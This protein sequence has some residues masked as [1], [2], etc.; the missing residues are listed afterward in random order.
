V[1]TARSSE[2][3]VG[4]V[5]WLVVAAVG[6]A[7]RPHDDGS[8]DDEPDRDSEDFR[9]GV[10]VDDRRHNDS[11]QQENDDGYHRVEHSP[12]LARHPVTQLASKS[13]RFPLV[14]HAEVTVLPPSGSCNGPP[15]T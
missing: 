10:Q 2:T 5:D 9:P 1:V 7:G 8:A 3:V 11:G 14:A 12:A 13:G 15:V 6:S 4:A